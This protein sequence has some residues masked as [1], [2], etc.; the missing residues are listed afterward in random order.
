MPD[1]A[2]LQA[3]IGDLDGYIGRRAAGLAD[4]RVADV[5]ADCARQVEMAV[6]NADLRVADLAGRC[7]RAEDVAAELRRRDEIRER[8][9]AGLRAELEA[10]THA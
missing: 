6:E 4:Q 7:Q 2:S 1:L 3:M 9:V 8:V 10:R 5:R